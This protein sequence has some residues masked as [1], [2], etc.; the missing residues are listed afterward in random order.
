MTAPTYP[1]QIRRG[2]TFSQA[3]L[4]ASDKLVYKLITAMP[5]QA[6]VRLAVADHGVPDQ[7]PVMVSGVKNPYQLNTRDC[8]YRVAT[9][10]DADTLEL[11]DVNALDWKA[12]SP[13]SGVVVYNEPAPLDAWEA[14]AQVRDRVGGN[15]LFT[16]SSNPASNADG[17]ITIDGAVLTLTID[18]TKTA[19]F[20]WHTGV[21]DIEVEL[22]G[23]VRTIIAT[24]AVEVLGEVTT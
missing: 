17:V 24:S 7:W 13:V 10:V 14:R 19:G 2:R 5:S 3:Y 6:P 21:Y 15:L 8:E 12:F 9:V 23:E 1:I 22:N 18:A 4:Y 20:T 11:N 16:W